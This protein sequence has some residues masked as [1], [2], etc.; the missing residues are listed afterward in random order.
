MTAPADLSIFDRHATFDPAGDFEA[1][2]KTVPARWAVYLLVDAN[3]QPVQLLC[4]KNLRYSL[5]H[6][7]GPGEDAPS[8]RV[9]YREIVRKVHYRRVDSAFEADWLY[10]EAARA[11]FPATYHG[12]LGFRQTW[13]VHVD[14][15]S[16]FPRFVKTNDPAARSGVLIGPVEDKHAAAR[17]IELIEDLFDLCRYYN[18][19]TEAPHGRPCAYKEMGKCP[20]PCDGSIS[21][22]QYR[23]LVEWAT[24]VVVDPAQAVREHSQRMQ[25]AAAEL[26]FES[27]GK[28][29][30]YIDQLSLLGKGSFRHVRRIEDFRY[31][32]LQRGPGEGKARVFLI[33]PGRIEEIADLIAEP[34]RPSELLR[35]ALEAAETWQPAELDPAGVERIAV[36]SH[37][38]FQ[39]KGQGVFLPLESIDEKSLT[40]AYRELKKQK[41]VEEG[42]TAEGMVRELGGV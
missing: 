3:D 32:T 18:I 41:P 35:L 37:H 16:P 42:E 22:D 17:L 38:L 9:N 23:R 20:S 26:R 34:A 8:K 33:L 21:M 12:M 30:A 13:F 6:R 36:A 39:P 2:L 19:L 14:P 29:K 24:Q 7:L 10:L 28:I 40:R 31:L 11:V 25:A 27:A 1:F 5:E 15:E 4:V